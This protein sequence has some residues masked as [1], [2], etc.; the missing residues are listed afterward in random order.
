MAQTQA[1]PRVDRINLSRITALYEESRNLASAQE[2]LN[3][4]GRIVSMTIGPGPSDMGPD[5][6]PMMRMPTSIS[7]TGIEYP[8]A[9][10]DAIKTALAER[11][12]AITAAL[13]D[14]GVI[15]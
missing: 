1:Q 2:N 11:Q 13:A 15:S 12:Q 3:S 4:G 5:A 9:M 6:P 10:V 7:T 8:A 14:L